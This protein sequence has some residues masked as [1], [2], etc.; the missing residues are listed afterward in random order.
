MGPHT[1]SH[2]GPTQFYTNILKDTRR[3]M[4][5]EYRKLQTHT[6]DQIVQAIVLEHLSHHHKPRTVFK[7]IKRFQWNH[8]QAR[9]H[10]KDYYDN[11][12]HDTSGKEVLFGSLW[13]KIFRNDQNDEDFDQENIELVPNNKHHSQLRL[14]PSTSLLQHPR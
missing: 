10:I 7:S 13:S 12:I 5:D 9:P 3:K 1:T 6:W 8:K 4:G 11:K 14:P 2:S